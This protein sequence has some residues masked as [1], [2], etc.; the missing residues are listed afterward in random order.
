[1]SRQ[2][3][4]KTVK[5]SGNDT[6]AAAILYFKDIIMTPLKNKA[7]RMWLI[8]RHSWNYAP[9]T[10]DKM[11]EIPLRNAMHITATGSIVGS[12]S[13]MTV[14]TC[15]KSTFE[16]SI[17]NEEAVGTLVPASLIAVKRL[18]IFSPPFRACCYR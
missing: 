3:A 2:G 1:M 4:K 5:N 9:R 14:S 6:I 12:K 7:A 15:I 16:T 8:G 13:N 18:A 11:N 17:L 10:K